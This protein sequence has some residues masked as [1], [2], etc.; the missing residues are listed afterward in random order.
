MIYLYYKAFH[1][2]AVIAWMVSL[3]YLPRLFVY[4][5]SV[6][7]KSVTYDIFLIMEKRLLYFISVTSII[8]TYLIGVLLIIENLDLLSE[9]YFI[10]KVLLV[11]FLT[12]YRFHLFL[13]FK[14]FEKRANTKIS[15]Y[16]RYINKIP[17][18]LM[19]LIILLVVVKPDIG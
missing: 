19:I 15:S 12:I 7:R 16:Y 5:S 3:L 9:N 11:L 17:T 1:I 14:N 10:I 18:I 6:L 2:V 4:H 8:F 13:I